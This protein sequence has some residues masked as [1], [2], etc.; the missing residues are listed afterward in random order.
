METQLV[1][2]KPWGRGWGGGVIGRNTLPPCSLLGRAQ[3]VLGEKGGYRDTRPQ[4]DMEA[5]T[6]LAKLGFQLQNYKV[7]LEILG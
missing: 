6:P 3:S 1:S 4:T 2:P 7:G 5:P